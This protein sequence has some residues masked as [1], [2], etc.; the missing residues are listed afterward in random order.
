MKSPPP[1]LPP[2]EPAAIWSDTW[3]R[4]EQAV[5]SARHPF[6]LGVFATVRNGAPEQRTV[7]LRGAEEAHRRVT[8]HTDLRSPKARDLA[9][10]GP[11]SWLFYD[12]PSRLQVRMTGLATLHHEGDEVDRRWQGSRPQSQACY[13]HASGPGSPLDGPL[14]YLPA[15]SETHQ[16]DQG[17]AH[18]AIVATEITSLEWLSLHH[19]G[20]RRLQFAIGHHGVDGSWIAP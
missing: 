18:F 17:R 16:S 3:Q 6:H 5:V 1:P 20:H 19:A 14:D 7:V 9:Q 11:A 2:L 12:A 10:P 8:F 4:L 13:R 15:A